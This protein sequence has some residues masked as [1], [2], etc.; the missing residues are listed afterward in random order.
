MTSSMEN[1]IKKPIRIIRVKNSRTSSM[2][3]KQ[4]FLL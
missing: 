2:K 4:A 3:E 1:E